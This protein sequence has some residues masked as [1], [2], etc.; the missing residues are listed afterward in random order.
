[1]SEPPPG[2]KGKGPLQPAWAAPPSPRHHPEEAELGPLRPRGSGPSP[3]GAG[4]GSCEQGPRSWREEGPGEGA[5]KA[6]RTRSN[7]ILDQ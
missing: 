3:A 2:G 1:M 6:I 5:P 7:A 4:L